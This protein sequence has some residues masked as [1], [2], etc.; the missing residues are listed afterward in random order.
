MATA[1]GQSRFNPA[2]LTD[3]EKEFR[4]M[5]NNAPV[6]LWMTNVAGNC[7]FFNKTWREFTGSEAIE[8]D[9]GW[10][11]LIHPDD[12]PAIEKL[13]LKHFAARTPYRSQYRL[14][15]RDGAYRWII[16]HPAPY[17]DAQNRFA[18]FISSCF[19]FH[20]Q[21][22]Q[23]AALA[24]SA[25]EQA[26][27]AAFGRFA[28]APRLFSE[29]TREAA[30]TTLDIL[31]VDCVLLVAVNHATLQLTRAA[32]ACRLGSNPP[33]E[34]GPVP[35][36]ALAYARPVLMDE[37]PENF[38]VA[39]RLK[40]GGIQTALACPIGSGKQLY[41]FILASTCARR[42]F[43]PEAIEFIQGIASTLGTV[44]Q[45]DRAEKALAE[46]EQRLLQSQKAGAIGLLAGGLA[47][48]FKNLLTVIRGYTELMQKDLSQLARLPAAA[49]LLD[50]L[51]LRNIRARHAGI[52]NAAG[53]AGKL[54]RQLLDFSRG[55]AARIERNDLNE[56]ITGVKELI[57]A[58][59]RGGIQLN[60]ALAP[61]P[62]FAR[63]DRNQIEQVILN[64]AINARDA[65]PD[66][67]A[68]TIA[69]ETSEIAG[70]AAAPGATAHARAKLEKGAYAK[71]TVTDTGTGIP[72]EIQ[73][74]IF[75][76]FFTTK[77]R[78]NGTGLGLP[79]C[80]NIVQNARGS[81]SFETTPGKG[82]TFIVLLPDF[83][84]AHA[85]DDEFRA[86]STSFLDVPD[87][88]NAPPDNASPDNTPPDNAPLDN[89]PPENTTSDNTTPDAELP[90]GTETLLLVE[91]D[92]AILEVTTEILESLGYTVRAYA[93]GDAL[94]AQT[95]AAATATATAATANSAAAA[96]VTA[97]NATPATANA[98]A[99]TANANANSARDAHLLI[100]DLNMP[101]LGGRQLAARMRALQPGL[102]VLFISGFT[103]DIAR[104][105]EDHFLEKPF[106]RDHLAR[107]V[108][109]ALQ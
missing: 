104:Q 77:K 30:R 21:R 71:I 54:T 72:P 60:L 78:N 10:R 28:L 27:L 83:D 18:G 33:H 40:A 61:A 48:D 82:T 39:A 80:A 32:L 55:Q 59:L 84:P 52:I 20:E 63:V 53:R 88:D 100:T 45:R 31:D 75:L 85:G 96:N 38:P 44:N 74:K 90:A 57:A 62:V 89:A 15:H 42:S 79:T 22:E 66:G 29:L 95:T 107:K 56:L 67:G 8:A 98:N 6:L 35:P 87:N 3:A 73:P 11:K 7:F 36:A 68:L 16:S 94:L 76:P 69:T 43:T 2:P 13:Y 99:A 64:L 51:P 34:L 9:V 108:R 58:F 1:T 97:A 81:I 50:A 26:S 37:D 65:M 23:E 47:H 24:K 4:R 41:G 101:G 14:R 12:R 103:A 102:R 105:G 106:T 92:Q 49:P 109:E 17:Y 5:T 46:S 25:R 91:D 93:S 70:A 86:Q 19:D